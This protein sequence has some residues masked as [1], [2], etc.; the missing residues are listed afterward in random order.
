M[1]R[2]IIG[3][4]GGATKVAGR[5]IERIEAGKYALVKGAVFK[6]YS[7]HP[8]FLKNFRPVPLDKQIKAAA[9]GDY[10]LAER[11]K[12]QGQ[13]YVDSVADVI[14]QLSSDEDAIVGIAMPGIKTRS[15]MGMA[16]VANGPRIPDFCEKLQAQLQERG[17]NFNRE[18][19]PLQNDSDMCAV[20]EEYSRIGT[21]RGVN[22]I[23][24]L[25]GGTGTAD[26]MKL[27][28]ELISF[29]SIKDWIAKSWELG[30]EKG[31]SLERYS[32]MR[33]IQAIYADNDGQ[34][35]GSPDQIL[36]LAILG[37][38]TAKG[39]LNK[40]GEKLGELIFER[41]ETIFAGWQN[42]FQ[43]I[44]PQRGAL[45]REHPYRGTL[46]DRIVLGQRLAELLRADSANIIKKPLFD[47]LTQRSDVLDSKARDHYQTNGK[48]REELI[49]LST[50]RDAPILGVGIVA[51]NYYKNACP[52]IMAFE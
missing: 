3:I 41:I 43:F 50:L 8:S 1:M 24:Y 11:E 12:F 7:Q 33:G 36:A 4:D 46:L 5:I 19:P 16:V 14:A 32:S 30:D 52:S 9:N 23:Y 37:D 26:A 6:T 2:K 18:F 17:I 27:N 40:V 51:Y 42:R 13:V 22:N 15:G 21:F 44:N 45:S 25:G 20:G 28:G 39:V 47:V 48:F 38:Q 34:V 35:D 31:I 10:Q 49:V 29:D